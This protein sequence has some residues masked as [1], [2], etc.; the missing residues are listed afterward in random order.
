M[1]ICDPGIV[2]QI[3]NV[4]RLKRGDQIIILDGEGGMFRCL[5]EK[6]TATHVEA[7]IIDAHPA[8]GDPCVAVTVALPPLKGGRF[9]WALQK[10]TELGVYRVVPIATSRSV[11]KPRS[12]SKAADTS[13][14]TRWQAIMREAAEQCERASIPEMRP[15]M[16]LS[17]FLNSELWAPES[18]QH[19]AIV[20]AERSEAPLFRNVLAQLCQAEP[21]TKSISVVIG[22]E[23]GLTKDELERASATGGEVVSLGRRIL[24]SETAAIYALVQIIFMLGDS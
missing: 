20:C 16:S 17:T 3:R 10:L 11:V 13:K 9:E 5:L 19:A 15:P 22:P 7:R 4:L 21:P 12:E 18:G 8:I 2:S 24:R 6:P 14:L 1:H 23:G